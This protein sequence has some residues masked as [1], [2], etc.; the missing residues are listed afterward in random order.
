MA[1]PEKIDLEIV[2]PEGPDPLTARVLPVRFSGG[3][4]ST[5]PC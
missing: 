4:G 1:L 2:T 3:C 5:Q